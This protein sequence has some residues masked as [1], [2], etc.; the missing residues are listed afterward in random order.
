MPLSFV[1]KTTEE[2]E[3]ANYGQPPQKS[4]DNSH[5]HIKAK[6]NDSL[7]REQFDLTVLVAA[8]RSHHCSE[9]KTSA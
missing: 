6:P 3:H 9:S 1:R 7:E 4:N 2:F 5:N 8:R